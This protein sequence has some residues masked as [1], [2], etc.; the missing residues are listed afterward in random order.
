MK[1]TRKQLW[2]Y[3]NNQE[4][5]YSD[6]LDCCDGETNGVTEEVFNELKDL[7]DD[8]VRKPIRQ[9]VAGQYMSENRPGGDDYVAV[10]DDVLS[11]IEG[12]YLIVT[13]YGP[14]TEVLI[15][16]YRPDYLT[17]EG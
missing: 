17:I 10:V 12:G 6:F 5:T 11:A 16:G 15:A 8:E 1:V 13:W 14:K 9:I 4:E 3:L 7:C 2:T